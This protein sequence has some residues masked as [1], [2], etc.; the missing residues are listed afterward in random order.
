MQRLAVGTRGWLATD[1][2]PKLAHVWSTQGSWRVMPAIALQEKSLKLARLLAC[3]L[4]SRL[5]LVARLSRQTTLFGKNWLFAF[6]SHPTIYRPLYLRYSESFQREFWER[7]P[8]EKQDWFIHNLHIKTLQIPLFSSSSLLH[9][10]E[11]HYQNLFS[12]YSYLWEGHLVFGKQ[13]RRDQFHIGWCYGQV[14][15][16]GKLKK[17]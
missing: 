2:P 17:K 13:I 15:E 12:P 16:S 6:L 8:R 5:H 1:K 3:D 4:N 11:V 14:V 9:P 7:N 10:W